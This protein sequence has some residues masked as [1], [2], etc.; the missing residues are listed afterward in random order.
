MLTWGR[1]TK[2]E[3]LKECF[4]TEN[5]FIPISANCFWSAKENKHDTEKTKQAKKEWKKVSVKKLF[6]KAT[7]CW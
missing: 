5:F 3:Y 1:K 7:D 2:K 6:T 4:A